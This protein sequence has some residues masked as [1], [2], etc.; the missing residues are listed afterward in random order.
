MIYSMTARISEKIKLGNQPKRICSLEH[1]LCFTQTLPVDRFPVELI[2]N[3]IVKSVMKLLFTPKMFLQNRVYKSNAYSIDEF[4]DNIR[5]EMSRLWKYV[6]LL[7]L[8]KNFIRRYWECGLQ[9]H[10]T[11]KNKNTGQYQLLNKNIIVCMLSLV[12]V[13]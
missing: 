2:G 11:L 7:R 6:E 12:K 3:S 4:K 5:R 9:T 8:N 1:E 13:I 10:T